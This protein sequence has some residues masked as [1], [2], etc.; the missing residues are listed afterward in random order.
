V[1]IKMD[2]VLWQF[3]KF[4]RRQFN[5]EYPDMQA[6]MDITV[7][8]TL[9]AL[10]AHGEAEE[11]RGAD[12]WM[13]RATPKLLQDTGLERGPTITLGPWINETV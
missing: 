3:A 13:W 4:Y 10:A 9:Q 8:A 11:E 1:I 2:S 12:V 5:I 6:G 7:F